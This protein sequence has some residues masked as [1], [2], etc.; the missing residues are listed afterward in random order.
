[1]GIVSYAQNFEDVMLWRALGHIPNGFY[2]DVGA[3]HPTVDSVSKAF[4]ENGWRGIH[5]EATSTYANM[6]R[7]DRPDELVLQVA[8]SDQPGTMTFYEIPETGLSTG[9]KEIAKNHHSQGF[10]VHEITVPCLTL[11]DVFE[12]AAKRDIHWLKIDVEGMERQVLAGW[13]TSNARPWV[14]AVESTYPNSQVETHHVWENFVTERGYKEAYFDGLSRYYVLVDLPE[15]AKC[16]TIPPN[17][18]D[19]FSLAQTTPYAAPL[20]ALIIQGEKQLQDTGTHKNELSAQLSSL[21]EDN[22]RLQVE[23]KQHKKS[24]SEFAE[25]EGRQ[26]Q[27]ILQE[28]KQASVQLSK[29]HALREQELQKK[30]AAL[31]KE[32]QTRSLAAIEKEKSAA[33][34]AAL[35][36]TR[37]RDE[38]EQLVHAH[39]M[40]EQQIYA[41]LHRVKESAAHLQITTTKNHASE[42]ATLRQKIFD[43]EYEALSLR[44]AQQLLIQQYTNELDTKEKSLTMKLQ[45]HAAVE[46]KLYG[47]I[48]VLQQA[49]N[50]NSHELTQALKTVELLTSDLETSQKLNEWRAAKLMEVRQSQRVIVGNVKS[51]KNMQE[52]VSCHDEEFV[53]CAYKTLLGREPDQEGLSY[54]LSRVRA[55]H[56]KKL[57]LAQLYLSK[58]CDRWISTNPNLAVSTRKYAWLRYPILGRLLVGIGRWLDH[59]ETKNRLRA[60]ENQIT[61]VSL[62]ANPSEPDHT[63]V[64]VMSKA[65]S[66]LRES[67]EAKIGVISADQTALN[68]LSASLNERDH[69][70]VDVLSKEI[71]SLRE[72]LEAKISMV[73]AIRATPNVPSTAENCALDHSAIVRVKQLIDAGVPRK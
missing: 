11:V 53:H 70:L 4:Y 28:N 30:I 16:F 24:L 46:A 29:A 50:Q 62:S 36:A 45:N 55:G 27:V 15:I 49:S 64:D 43:L 5:V 9:D 39:A 37:A 66:N 68:S 41:E 58:E 14:L 57:V 63:H 18:F 72:S 69:T 25:R 17:I 60:I 73:S 12:Q 48:D 40:F 26:L 65:I 34:Q 3:Q 13:G 56:S 21:R 7:E 19:G 38:K 10:Q 47:D 54:Y 35:A 71:F 22:V 23:T 31:E 32:G 1:M 59:T 8:L 6:L 44:N 61:R 33:M 52:L 2:I 51:A 20:H 67:L 42:V